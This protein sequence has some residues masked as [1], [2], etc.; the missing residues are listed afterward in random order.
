M[1]KSH[2]YEEIPYFEIRCPHCGK[3][4][5]YFGDIILGFILHCKNCQKKFEIGDYNE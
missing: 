3:Y 5:S 2:K 1:K 4:E